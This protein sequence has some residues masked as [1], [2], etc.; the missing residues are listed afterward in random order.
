MK[1]RPEH[2]EYFIEDLRPLQLWRQFF[3]LLDLLHSGIRPRKSLSRFVASPLNFQSSRC[4]VRL[5]SGY[6]FVRWTRMTRNSKVFQKECRKSCQESMSCMG[7]FWCCPVMPQR[8]KTLQQLYLRHIHPLSGNSSFCWRVFCCLFDLL[9]LPLY[10][11]VCFC[12]YIAKMILC[13]WNVIC[14]RQDSLRR[15]HRW[16]IYFLGYWS[17][18]ARVFSMKR[19]NT[20]CKKISPLD[21]TFW[22]HWISLITKCPLAYNCNARGFKPA[23]SIFAP[24]R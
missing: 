17:N 3:Q 14:W 9:S 8:K 15:R 1:S 12:L 19:L 20:K 13:V 5:L 6:V 21:P 22:Y 18:I 16:V 23:E 4:N 11:S 10:C 7:S 2:L 24:W